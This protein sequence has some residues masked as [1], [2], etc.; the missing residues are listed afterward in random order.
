MTFTQKLATNS[1]GTHE[2]MIQN[3]GFEQNQDLNYERFNVEEGLTMDLDEWEPRGRLRLWSGQQLGALRTWWHRLHAK[4]PVNKDHHQEG[5]VPESEHG[6]RN[7]SAHVSQATSEAAAKTDLIP[8]WFRPRNKTIEKIRKYTHAYLEEDLVNK[9][10]KKCAEILVKSR[11]E[12]YEADRQRWERTCFSLWYQ[13][14]VT[15]CPY[16]ETHFEKKQDME[17]HLLEKHSNKFS[18]A[19]EEERTALDSALTGCR[20]LVQ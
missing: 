8:S 13:C 7:G 20:I 6:L 19:S 16:A 5:D 3:M 4:S 9:N 10:V 2:R 12:R 14:N 11:R 18:D 1:E 17:A 15:Q